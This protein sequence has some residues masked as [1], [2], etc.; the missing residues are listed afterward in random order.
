MFGFSVREEYSI[1]NSALSASKA[2]VLHSV[3]YSVPLN[4]L[5]LVHIGPSP[6]G[7]TGDQAIVLFVGYGLSYVPPTGVSGIGF[8][9]VGIYLQNTLI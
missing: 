4:I 2:G 3:A 9:V 6:E 8:Y 1:S 7:T 5:V